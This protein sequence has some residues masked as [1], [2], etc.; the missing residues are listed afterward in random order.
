MELMLF[1][2]FQMFRLSDTDGLLVILPLLSFLPWGHQSAVMLFILLQS[3]GFPAFTFSLIA[4]TSPL[5]SDLCLG[6]DSF[7]FFAAWIGGIYGCGT[8][9]I[10]ACPFHCRLMAL[11]WHLCCSP[12]FTVCCMP[13]LLA[14]SCV[15][16]IS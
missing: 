16:L 6:L 1:P 14:Q 9:L 8:A 11:L 4:S 15:M 13:S 5:S 12:F 10:S 7:C 3:S 2:S